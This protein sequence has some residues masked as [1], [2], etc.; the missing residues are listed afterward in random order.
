M[1]L[2]KVEKL[3]MQFGGIVAVNAVDL[4]VEP[5]TNLSP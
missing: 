1:S 3:T 2:L 5:G 4:T